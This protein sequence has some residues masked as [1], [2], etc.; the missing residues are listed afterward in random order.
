M[1]MVLKNCFTEMSF[2]EM[3]SLDGGAWSWKE[4]SKQ[5]FGGAAAGAAGGAVTGAM[6]GGVGAGPGALAGGVGGAVTGG[7][8]YLLIGWW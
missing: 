1:E 7:V 2:D 5:V 8:L 4:F 6:Y 3:L